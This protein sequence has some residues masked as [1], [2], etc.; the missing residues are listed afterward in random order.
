MRW[1]VFWDGVDDVAAVHDLLPPLG[2][3]GGRW[4]GTG[5]DLALQGVAGRRNTHTLGEFSSPEAVGYL[6]DA[7]EEQGLFDDPYQAGELAQVLNGHP[8]SLG[9]AAATMVERRVGCGRFRALLEERTA[10]MEQETSRRSGGA[11]VAVWEL[12]VD[13]ADTVCRPPWVPGALLDLW[14]HVAPTAI[15]RSLGTTSRALSHLGERARQRA[16]ENGPLPGQEGPR[17][18]QSEESIARRLQEVSAL[19]SDLGALGTAGTAARLDSAQE[20]SDNPLH[21]AFKVTPAQVDEACAVLSRLGLVVPARQPAE[22]A[23][24]AATVHGI[25]PDLQRMARER[26][27]TAITLEG[28]MMLLL[29]I[30][31]LHSPIADDALAFPAYDSA[32]RYQ[33]RRHQ[34]TF[35]GRTLQGRVLRDWLA[36]SNTD[37][38]AFSTLYLGA[39]GH[40]AE[41]LRHSEAR[42]EQA[43]LHDRENDFGT[44]LAVFTLADLC[45]RTGDARRAADLGRQLRQL[46]TREPSDLFHR[47]HFAT[48]A[49]EAGDP[50]GALRELRELDAQYRARIAEDP[51]EAHPQYAMFL[52]IQLAHWRGEVEGAAVAV[53]ELS[54]IERRHRNLKSG[55]RNRLLDTVTQ[56]RIETRTRLAHWQA[57]AGDRTG[58]ALTWEALIPELVRFYGPAHEETLLVRQALEHLRERNTRG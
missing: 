48:W 34:D 1:A 19:V 41:A 2:Q 20:S 15:P 50:A 23:D 49:G 16:R 29:E 3:P 39:V 27:D 32:Y 36:E 57:R 35:A 25:H 37:V 56:F 7:L 22:W 40:K 31:G 6:R 4:V 52:H 11:A 38:L 8:Q 45:A 5:Q 43:R 30:D 51:H 58:S 55:G 12:A 28:A 33:V 18:E 13:T 9:L 17:G 14:S 26:A 44:R 46:W 54:D 53:R 10:Q 21:H 42:V 24:G 47:A